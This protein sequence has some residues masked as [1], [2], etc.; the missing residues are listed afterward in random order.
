MILITLGDNT[1]EDVRMILFSFSL[2][3]DATNQFI[4]THAYNI[5]IFSQ[6]QDVFNGKIG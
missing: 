5:S 6:L 1:H 3:N 4:N 2:E